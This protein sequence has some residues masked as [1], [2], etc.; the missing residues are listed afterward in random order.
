MCE[1][2]DCRIVEVMDGDADGDGAAASVSLPLPCSFDDSMSSNPVD[3]EDRMLDGGDSDRAGA[4]ESVLS[5]DGGDA[6]DLES[7]LVS[8]SCSGVVA[9]PAVGASMRGSKMSMPVEERGGGGSS[10]STA[11]ESRQPVFGGATGW[12]SHIA[13]LRGLA[14]LFGSSRVD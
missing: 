2:G 5:C 4:G 3:G 1:C 13:P 7:D 8:S 9:M 12:E 10:A 6:I 11:E 14:R